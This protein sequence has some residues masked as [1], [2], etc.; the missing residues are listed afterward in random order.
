MER[1]RVG[2]FPE[3]LLSEPFLA[4][5]PWDIKAG[6]SLMILLCR[7]G[8]VLLPAVARKA[9]KSSLAGSGKTRR[10]NAEFLGHGVLKR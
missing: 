2:H 1:Y 7:K 9:K 3:P 6:V 10:R 5:S 4:T 8:L